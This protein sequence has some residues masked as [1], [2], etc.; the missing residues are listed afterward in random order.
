MKKR[1][2]LALSIVIVLLLVVFGP[3]L[4]GLYRLDK[5]VTSSSAAYRVER[6]TWPHLID[7][8][9]GC[10][11]V[12]GNSANQ[13]YPSLAGQPAAYLETQLHNLAGGQRSSPNMA[14]LAMTM[15]DQEVRFY[16][17]YF[18]RLTP[19]E[20]RYFVADPQLKER[21]R[22]LAT[23]GNCAACH[24][25]RLMGHD[26]FPRLSG[27]GYDYLVA[28]FDAFASGRRS[29]PTGVMKSISVGLSPED[30]KAVATYLASLVPGG[31]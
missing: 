9:F 25:A 11:G 30:R 24:G 7:E 31:Q 29:E 28:Q 2:V 23:A 17:G 4:L 3:D 12:K 5:F 1:I 15:S 21:G 20:N 16:A 6:G 19:A 10:H 22:L 18:S 26:Q 14:P 13:H 8:C 27:Q